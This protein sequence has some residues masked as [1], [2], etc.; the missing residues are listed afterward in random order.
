M[1]L[2]RSASALHTP[3]YVAQQLSQMLRDCRES[4]AGVVGAGTLEDYR[5]EIMEMRRWLECGRF[6]RRAVNRRLRLY[7]TGGEWWMEC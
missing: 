4:V 7:A 1:G 5:E 3:F 6:D 2:H